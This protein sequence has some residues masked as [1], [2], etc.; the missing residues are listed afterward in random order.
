M[1]TFK[2]ILA[3][4]ARLIVLLLLILAL[5]AGLEGLLL[6]IQTV[7]A[8]EVSG[9]GAL[10]YFHATVTAFMV[11]SAIVI[12]Y[13]L[14]LLGRLCWRSR[15]ALGG[16]PASILC[17]LA[18]AT[19]LF[20][21]GISAIFKTPIR[22]GV[23]LSSALSDL[24]S[25]VPPSAP[26]AHLKVPAVIDQASYLL[27]RFTGLMWEQAGA[28]LESFPISD[29]IL[30]LTTWVLVAGAVR[31]AGQDVSPAR[32]FTTWWH[33]LSDEHRVVYGIV[34]MLLT[35]SYLSIT[36]IIALPGLVG[37]QASAAILTKDRLQQQ[38]TQSV[39][40]A[41][42]LTLP[43]LADS[44]GLKLAI[45][46]L[47]SLVDSATRRL[48][49]RQS[50][51]S[52]LKGDADAILLARRS[53]SASLADYASDLPELQAKYLADGLVDFDTH[54][55]AQ[56]AA[57]DRATFVQWIN[58]WFQDAA[59]S[60]YAVIS[61]ADRELAEGDR[62][63]L[64]W[65]RGSRRS[66]ERIIDYSRLPAQDSV[67]SPRDFG[68]LDFT[69]SLT[70]R[71][72]VSAYLRKGGPEIPSPPA[73][74]QPGWGWGP[75]RKLAEPLL[76]ARSLPLAQITGMLGFGLLGAVISALRWRGTTSQTSVSA[77]PAILVNAFSAT[78]L[79]FL[80]VKGGLAVF[81]AGDNEPNSYVLFFSCLAGA[82]YSEDV[83]KAARE[84]LAEAL[85]GSDKS[86]ET[87][88]SSRTDLAQPTGQPDTCD[89]VTQSEQAGD[90]SV[91]T[92]SK[93]SAPAASEKPT[94]TS[95]V[96]EAAND[97]P[98]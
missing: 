20:P 49:P 36:A 76:N 85:K 51:L 83:W 68:L 21:S 41:K 62:D 90:S 8:S 80:F 48:G 1:D 81:A 52:Y 58:S 97:D 40:S 73:P 25:R 5:A 88:R 15:V 13:L 19:F 89:G 61:E 77:L 56:M 27:H 50:S 39:I 16:D 23:N 32:R 72:S 59:S 93:D 47:I 54:A 60:L 26:D 33:A 45:D 96:Q 69:P 4:L 70:P 22:Y 63:A 65:V 74:P 17:G 84:R 14:F 86:Q 71:Y 2:R 31:N 67:S 11:I 98:V 18:V 38:L 12:A 64:Q 44:T 28:I 78:L 30:A 7:D 57:N 87:G 66:V 79:V 3:L 91:S 42:A 24:A 6:L 9:L 95:N 46:S 94:D 92:A 29:A 53:L 55:S 82:V 37:D 75:F 43:R 34:S 35:G 10:A